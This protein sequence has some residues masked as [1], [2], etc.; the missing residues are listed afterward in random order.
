MQQFD[1]RMAQQIYQGKRVKLGNEVAFDQIKHEAEF[2][3]WTPKTNLL[4]KD[5]KD[6]PA[7]V[8]NVSENGGVKMC[9]VMF[10]HGENT[11][12]VGRLMSNRKAKLR[13]DQLNLVPDAPTM[14]NNALQQQPCGQLEE[15]ARE[16]VV[17]QKNIRHLNQLMIH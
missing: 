5:F 13:C 3:K 16:A 15:D 8:K 17:T 7:T 10:D 9:I 4:W 12:L 2:C 11:S 14:Q 1:L 6:R